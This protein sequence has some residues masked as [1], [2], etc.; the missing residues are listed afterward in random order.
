MKDIKDIKTALAVFEK[1]AINH[2]DST[3]K[4]DYNAG[5]KFYKEITKAAEYIKNEKSVNNL[6]KFLSHESIG[7]RMWAAYYLLPIAE[8]ESER[9]LKDI[10]NSSGIHSL[11][12]DT[13]LSEWKKGNL[14]F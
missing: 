10:V 11:T 2:A 8:E 5:N 4:G 9:V 13:T 7:V 14:N 6:K 12:A 1:A 3:E